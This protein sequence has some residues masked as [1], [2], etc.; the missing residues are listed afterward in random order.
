MSTALEPAERR[1]LA[2]ENA[3]RAL[4]AARA[5]G[6]PVI[7]VCGSQEAAG[8]AGDAGAEVILEAHPSGQNPAARAGVEAAGARGHA[9]VLLVSSDLPLITAAA[10]RRVLEVGERS[11]DRSVVAAAATGRGGTN[12]L[13]LRPPDVIGLHF[14]DD[15]LA[16]FEADAR[17]HGVPFAV[18]ESA[19]L[20][21]DLDEPGDLAELVGH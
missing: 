8:L 4:A 15:S 1:R 10:L 19:E 18:H 11:G 16:K 20:A 21:L 5:T 12:A 13:Y 17:A 14:G 7:A 3:R 2:E 9:A 6:R